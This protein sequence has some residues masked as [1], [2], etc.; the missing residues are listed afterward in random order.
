[1]IEGLYGE[2]IEKIIDNEK[3]KVF[4]IRN[5]S[6]SGEIRVYN[7]FHGVDIIYNN[8]N[9]EY[10]GGDNGK[11]SNI[12][13]INHCKF[14]RYEC[15]FKKN[16]FEYISEGDLGIY[17]LES[18]KY[19]KA[20]FPNRQYYGLSILINIDEIRNMDLFKEFGIDIIRIYEK[21]KKNELCKI[22]RANEQIEH[23]FYEVYTYREKNK[24]YYLKIKII[25]LFLFLSEIDYSIE[26]NKKHL[27]R[28][29][30]EKAKSVKEFIIK[31]ITKHYKIE[32]LAEIFNISKTTIKSWFREVYG[33]GIYTYLKNYR[34]Q[35]A[36]RYLKET[37]Y[38]ILEI[39]N[40]IGYS[41][42]AKF[43]TAFKE[44]YGSS[45]K[46]FR[47]TIQMDKSRPIRVDNNSQID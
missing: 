14:G 11:I 5:K 17:L 28:F 40:I 26:S 39:S 46:E 33:V 45:P 20:V 34:L 13:E 24:L 23:I 32:E 7:L 44:T 27:T 10:C 30:V 25:E 19:S 16:R 9:L 3:E 35:E 41:N 1:M 22:V 2:T 12:M 4:N 37:N 15:E 38:S 18:K 36:L 43:S 31:D 21:V 6:G 47:N 29:Q 42:P 8:L